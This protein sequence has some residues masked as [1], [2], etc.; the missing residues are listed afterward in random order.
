MATEQQ[1]YFK[2]V[3]DKIKFNFIPVMDLRDNSIFGYKIIKDF[4]DLGFDDKDEMYQMAY[5][6]GFFEFFVLKLQE[7]AYKAAL[8]KN[9]NN[10]KLFYTLRMNLVK[11]FDFF[12]RSIENIVETYDLDYEQL[13]FEIKGI[14]SWKQYSEILN[15]MDE[16]YEC[17]IKENPT[18]PLNLNVLQ[19]IEPHL[20]EVK[21]LNTLKD[22]KSAKNLN[23]KILF[24]KNNEEKYSNSQL[25]KMGVDYVYSY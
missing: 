4:S 2:K 20:I 8:E 18:F 16:G 6:E 11:D 25:K 21:S 14:S 10:K 17:L 9:L 23:S 1:H 3:I 24:K 13:I 12:F 22:I 19:L 5:D 7:K 15:Y